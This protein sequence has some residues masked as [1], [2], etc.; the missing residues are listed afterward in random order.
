MVHQNEVIL[1]YTPHTLSA[2]K[3][4]RALRGYTA[5]TIYDIHLRGLCTDFRSQI[6]EQ[7][8]ICF[9]HQFMVNVTRRG[10]GGKKKSLKFASYH[11]KRYK[12][13]A[14]ISEEKQFIFLGNRELCSTKISLS[15]KL[16]KIKM[17]WKLKGPNVKRFLILPLWYKAKSQMNWRCQWTVS[18]TK[19][20][21]IQIDVR[22]QKL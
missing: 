3:I 15:I 22:T 18:R 17:I 16:N 1:R 4:Y 13:H 19:P 21:V 6:L 20:W 8:Y 10:K 9:Y 5:K 7:M 14:R 11:K 12:V 2:Y